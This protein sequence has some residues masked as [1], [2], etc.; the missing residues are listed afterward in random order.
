MSPQ[1]RSLAVIPARKGSKGLPGKNIKRLGGVALLQHIAKSALRV[2][3]AMDVI[4]STD[5]GEIANVGK[6][7]GLNTPA[8][9]PPS[10]ATDTASSADVMLHELEQAESRN[11]TRYEFAVLLQ[12]T[13]PF[14]TPETIE[15]ALHLLEKDAL[16]FVGTV[17]PLIDTHPAYML[18]N[19]GGDK[20]EPAFSTY[21]QTTR[22]GLEPFFARSGNVYATR[23]DA[24]VA[25]RSLIQ[26][27]A[28]YV[29]VSR[30]EATN[31]NDQY[32]W[33]I[34][35]AIIAQQERD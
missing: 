23:R 30:E 17:V 28:A 18:K 33:A 3:P 22:Q 9:R 2:S 10:L 6:A 26:A 8:L 34:A 16:D 13:C 32:D 5:D 4:L 11:G 19:S 35:E 27:N 24:L 29:R 14:T 15:R 12:P 20:F 25:N 1:A 7:A 21:G 31:I